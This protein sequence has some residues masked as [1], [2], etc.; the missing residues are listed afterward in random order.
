MLNTFDDLSSRLFS[1]LDKNRSTLRITDEVVNWDGNEVFSKFQYLKNLIESSSSPGARIGVVFPNWAVQGLV[2]LAALAAKRVPVL[3][4][5]SD[6]S[7]NQKQ[8]MKLLDCSLLFTIQGF[9]RAALG[10]MD[11]VTLSRNA[12]ID[13]LSINK[14]RTRW[15]HAM[16]SGTPA[17]TGLILFTSGSTGAPKGVCVPANGILKTAEFL[18]PYFNL[19]SQTR[20]PILLPICH[21]MGLNTQFIP[22][23]LAGGHCTFVNSRLSMNKIYRNILEQNATFVSLIGEILSTCWEE[24]RRRTLP[25]AASVRHI[26]LAGG[27]ISPRHLKFAKELFPNAVIHKGYGLTEAIRVTML[28]SNDPLFETGAVGKALPFVEIQIRDQNGVVLPISEVGEVYVRGCNT[29]LGIT[30]TSQKVLTSDGFLATG[31]LGSLNE[32]GH[33]SI[34]GRKDSLFKI[35][36]HRV[37]GSEIERVALESSTLIRNAK[38]MTLEDDRTG[39]MRI[40]LLLEVLKDL[41]LQFRE[42]HLPQIHAQMWSKFQKL[43]HF[44]REIL[45]LEHFQRTSNGKLALQKMQ[46]QC[47]ASKRVSLDE[48]HGKSLLRFFE[49]K[50]SH[51]MTRE[52][53]R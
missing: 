10:Q 45:I 18:I 33:L 7:A 34:T 29:L 50:N 5:Y 22:T 14:L 15:R 26:Q 11:F 30:G 9:D 47:K 43:P 53:S 39:R 8:W 46:E 17:G 23:V 32:T 20:T 31:D 13:E 40:V 28:N 36:G 16:S 41:Q 49:L 6:M 35:V 3:V 25:A 1:A 51:E 42:Q 52:L 19:D 12:E 27:M 44:P 37:S 21:S 38:C 24:K 2:T 48:N 4:S